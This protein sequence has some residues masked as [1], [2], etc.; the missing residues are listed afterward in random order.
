M[1]GQMKNL[2]EMKR[3]ADMIKRELEKVTTE[4]E[5]VKGIKIVINGVQSVQSMEI[6]PSHLNEHNKGQFER[7]LC[8]SVNAAIKKSQAVAARKMAGSLPGM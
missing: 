3:Q 2:M 8:R 4:S 7:D 6:D 5:E 1:F